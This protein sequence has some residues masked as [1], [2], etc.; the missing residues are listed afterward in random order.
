[1]KF[2]RNLLYEIAEEIGKER[3]SME[4]FITI[5]EENMCDTEKA[6]QSTEIEELMELGLPKYIC[7]KIQKKVSKKKSCLPFLAKKEEKKTVQTEK[8][9]R[10]VIREESFKPLED[11][12]KVLL[13]EYIS[14]KE[15]LDSLSMLKKILTNILE[16][17]ENEKFRKLNFN[18]NTLFMNLW[19]F[20]ELRRLLI[21]LNFEVDQNSYYLKTI[22]EEAFSFILKRIGEE[23][24]KAEKKIGSDFNPF[25][26]TYRTNNPTFDINIVSKMA[27]E[28]QP[29]YFNELTKLKKERENLI[30]NHK[31]TQ[32]VK[33]FK[34]DFETNKIKEEI[35]N[36]EIPI[37]IEN[38]KEQLNELKQRMINFQKNFYDEITFS[39]SRK[40]EFEELSKKEVYLETFLRI[41]LPNRYTIEV[42][43]HVN[44]KL[45][46]L[47]ELLDKY[48]I[49]KKDYFLFISP[50]VKNKFDFSHSE[51]KFTELNFVPD[52]NLNLLYSNEELNKENADLIVKDFV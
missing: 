49:Y 30:K 50:F 38:G 11:Q 48:L 13:N 22:P 47:F 42:N 31:I 39:N 14:S 19:K 33:I 24:E 45:G 16:N 41:K 37:N 52:A 9:E 18:N 29:D 27:K 26:P 10:I 3:E 25:Q 8:E 28:D 17:P 12:L 34:K 44:Q 43:F 5:L 35:D 40:K 36:D 20:H 51:K 32:Q 46:D 2:A 23:I 1:M 6:L 4:P 15:K 7:M 21:L